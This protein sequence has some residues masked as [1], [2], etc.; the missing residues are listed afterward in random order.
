MFALAMADS[1]SLNCCCSRSKKSVGDSLALVSLGKGGRKTRVQHNNSFSQ[2]IK[3]QFNIGRYPL[4]TTF[5][6]KFCFMEKFFAKAA[7]QNPE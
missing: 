7:R 6:P 2:D 1:C 3:K 4:A 5:H